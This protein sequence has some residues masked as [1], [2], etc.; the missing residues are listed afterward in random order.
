[1]VVGVIYNIVFK[2]I[3]EIQFNWKLKY[4]YV[5]EFC[6][7]DGELFSAR[8]SSRSKKYDLQIFLSPVFP[9]PIHSCFYVKDGRL[10]I[11]FDGIRREIPIASILYMRIYKCTI[12]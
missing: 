6:L 7:K 11:S 1:M 8:F 9:S 2:W 12:T 3:K 4:H 10:H 5:F